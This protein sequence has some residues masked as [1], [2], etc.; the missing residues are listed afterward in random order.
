MTQALEQRSQDIPVES[1]AEN[2][3]STL[4]DA[5]V[6]IPRYK[7]NAPVTDP[8]PSV[9]TRE[10]NTTSS[11][12]ARTTGQIVA[13]AAPADARTAD[14]V[15]L[16]HKEA[17]SDQKVAGNNNQDTVKV[18]PS[19]LN[20]GISSKE[21]ET[22]SESEHIVVGHV[23][24]L[25]PF[26]KLSAKEK[27]ELRQ[28]PAEAKEKSELRQFPDEAYELGERYQLGQPL[29]QY[30][31]V[32][33]PLDVVFFAWMFLSGLWLAA[34]VVVTIVVTVNFLRHLN[35]PLPPVWWLLLCGLIPIL[36]SSPLMRKLGK[37]LNGRGFVSPFS[38]HLRLYVYPEGFVRLRSRRPL[39]VR[40]E[41]VRRVR[42]L[43][44]DYYGRP[45]DYYI[46]TVH[47]ADG[48][49]ITLTSALT[50]IEELG[51]MMQGEY[52]I[53]RRVGVIA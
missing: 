3:S 32:Y 47:R 5:T 37:R 34:W 6:K 24:E 48:R 7:K 39:M 21:T 15:A 43:H 8:Q 25:T 31:V 40:W 22:R 23:E 53:R 51:R 16:E 29:A 9:T 11:N 49:V 14:A 30:K 44:P 36:C 26:M 38:A 19:R 45:F 35:Q 46:V 27:S 10:L 50:G 33:R 18:S 4:S 17:V 12:K 52:Y 20:K 1:T 28:F 2:N 41:Q 42:V 13:V